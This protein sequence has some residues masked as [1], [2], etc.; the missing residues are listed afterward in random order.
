MYNSHILQA[1]LKFRLPIIL[2]KIF[3]KNIISYIVTF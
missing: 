3:T 1:F 2:D